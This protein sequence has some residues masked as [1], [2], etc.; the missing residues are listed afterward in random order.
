MLSPMAAARQQMCRRV[1]LTGGP[2]GGRGAQAAG[3]PGGGRGAQA[4][5]GPAAGA[6]AG[7]APLPAERTALLNCFDSSL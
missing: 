7:R 2:G 1:G 6:R 3:G 4:A 5:G